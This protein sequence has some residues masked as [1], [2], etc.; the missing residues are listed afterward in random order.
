LKTGD[1]FHHTNRC[2]QESRRR[3]V[4]ELMAAIPLEKQNPRVPFSSKARCFSRTVR[5]GL[6]L[7]E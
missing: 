3:F 6:P 7:R 5:V 2:R 1:T 4:T